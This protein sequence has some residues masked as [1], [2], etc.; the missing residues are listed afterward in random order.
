MGMAPLHGEPRPAFDLLRELRDRAEQRLGRQLPV[1]SMGMS[2]DFEA[3]LEA[4]STMLRLGRAL[5]QTDG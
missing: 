1:L 5:F 2:E 4:G 3:A